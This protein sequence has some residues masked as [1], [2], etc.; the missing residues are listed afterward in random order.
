MHTDRSVGMIAK[1]GNND[2]T[3]ET[4]DTVTR[5]LD[6]VMVLIRDGGLPAV[7]LSAV[8]RKAGLS[9]GGLMHHYPSKEALVNAFLHRGG[10][11]HLALVRQATQPHPAGS[12]KRLRAYV[13]LF[14][15]ESTTLQCD[16]DRDC[17]AVMMALI[18]GGRD[19]EEVRKFYESLHQMLSGDGVS[20]DFLELV[21]ATVDGV[22]LQSVIDPL[23]TMGPRSER[24]RQS[25]TR[26][27]AD[28][29]AGK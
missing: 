4:P 27:I 2:Q 3:S 26:L 7:T 22:W 12:G 15:G 8:C 18:Q 9:K 1:M 17:A 5:I 29:I 20:D 14:L 24:I 19:S 10:E 23:E 21:L 13:D 6:A 25:L 16:E 28:E 11:E